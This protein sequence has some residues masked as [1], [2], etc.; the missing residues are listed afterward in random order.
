MVI[1]LPGDVLDGELRAHHLA[2]APALDPLRAEC[3]APSSRDRKNTPTP[4]RAPRVYRNARDDGSDVEGGSAS[5]LCD[6]R[7]Y[8][9]SSVS[10]HPWARVTEGVRVSLIRATRVLHRRVKSASP[11]RFWVDRPETGRESRQ[12]DLTRV[13]FLFSPPSLHTRF[14]D[15]APRSRSRR[16]SARRPR[17]GRRQAARQAWA[18]TSLRDGAISSPRDEATFWARVSPP[19]PPPQPPPHPLQP[20]SPQ[21]PWRVCSPGRLSSLPLRPWPLYRRRRRPVPQ[22]PAPPWPSP[23]QPPPPPPPS[24]RR[25]SSPPPPPL[26]PPPPSLRRPSSPRPPSPPRRPS[27]R[28]PFSPRPPSPPRRPS[29]RRPFSPRPPSPP[30][31]PS[32]PRPFS[33]RPPSPPRRPSLPRP[34]F[35]RLRLRVLV[36]ALPGGRRRRLRLLLLLGRGAGGVLDERLHLVLRLYGSAGEL[37]P[38]PLVANLA[39]DF[40]L[41]VRLLGLVVLRALRARHALLA[42]TDLLLEHA[43]LILGRDAQSFLFFVVS[44][45]SPVRRRSRVRSA[46]GGEKTKEKATRSRPPDLGQSR[47][48]EKKSLFAPR[49]A[50]AP[51][52]RRPAPRAPSPS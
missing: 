24:L 46:S 42:Q 8:P 10:G 3:R 30:R 52:R 26:R 33:P 35:L 13:C 14:L 45:A 21:Q 43:G 25:P 7:A 41:A 37:E 47:E 15:L 20:S 31:R 2:R 17:R 19:S 23:R 48:A 50:P 5:P 38:A 11:P 32:L 44:I 1:V 39:G 9:G 51:R 18:R 27:L 22:Q 36:G 16:T 29:L 28:R 12:L 40:L 6:R 34:F 4:L 49:T